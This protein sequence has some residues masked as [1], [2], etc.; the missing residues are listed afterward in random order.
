MVKERISVR[1]LLGELPIV[2]RKGT[3]SDDLVWSIIVENH[4]VVFSHS[5]DVKFYE[6]FGL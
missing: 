2:R 5:L 3:I 1:A 6:E 4:N